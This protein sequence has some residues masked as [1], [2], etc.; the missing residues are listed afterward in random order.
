MAFVNYETNGE[1]Y[2]AN[3]GVEDDTMLK[4][5]INHPSDIKYRE[6]KRIMVRFYYSSG[7]CAFSSEFIFDNLPESA[8]KFI[9]DNEIP[10]LN[11]N[12]RINPKT[13]ATLEEKNI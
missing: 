2:E 4:E 8:K 1:E 6:E 12:A 13:E 9:I 3:Y 5:M 11:S 10:I 7:V